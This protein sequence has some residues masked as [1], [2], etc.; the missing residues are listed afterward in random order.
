[1]PSGGKRPGA[2]KK[3]GTKHKKTLEQQMALEL[4]RNKILSQWKELI[5]AKIDL[6]LGVFE[7]KQVKGSGQVRVYSRLPDGGALEYLF[8][9]VVGRPRETIDLKVGELDELTKSIRSILDRKQGKIGK[10]SDLE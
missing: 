1:M 4:M 3:K 6:A 5:K 9:V 7:M 2:G 8:S 10:K